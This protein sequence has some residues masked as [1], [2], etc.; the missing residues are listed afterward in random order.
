[1]QLKKLKKKTKAKDFKKNKLQKKF[2]KL[3]HK[4]SYCYGSEA[5]VSSTFINKYKNL[6]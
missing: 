3:F 1:M 4:D 2:D 6:L 5:T